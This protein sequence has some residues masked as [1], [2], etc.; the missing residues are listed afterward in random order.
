MLPHGAG[1]LVSE[2]APSSRALET[3]QLEAREQ[4]E[5]EDEQ[6]GH[7]SDGASS[8]GS[9]EEQEQAGRGQRHRRGLLAS[10][11]I[12]AEKDAS[13]P[14]KRKR[15]PSRR[16]V[17]AAESA[18]LLEQVIA[19]ENRIAARSQ[20]H[21]G[22]FP[23]GPGAH[24]ISWARPDHPQRPASAD[25]SEW[26]TGNVSTRAAASKGRLG[27]VMGPYTSFA[28]E[29]DRCS[30]HLFRGD[31][32]SKGTSVRWGMEGCGSCLSQPSSS[33]R[34]ARDAVQRIPLCRRPL[35]GAVEPQDLLGFGV[36]LGDVLHSRKEQLQK[37][38]QQRQE[39]P[40]SPESVQQQEEPQPHQQQQA[41]RGDPAFVIDVAVVG[42]GVAG[43]AAA[44]YLRR[45]GATV[46]VFEGR[47][48][49]G[50]RTFSSVMPER[51]LPDGR[52]VGQVVIDLG[53]SY[54][55]CVAAKPKADEKNAGDCRWRR[56]P[57]RSVSGIAAVLQPLVADVAGKQN[58]ESTLFA[59]W[60]DEASGRELP[61]FSV[62]KVHEL[63]DRLRERTAAKLLH[64]PPPLTALGGPGPPSAALPNTIPAAEFLSPPLDRVLRAALKRQRAL[65]ARGGG[66]RGTGTFTIGGSGKVLTAPPSFA[67]SKGIGE[68]YSDIP[69]VVAAASSDIQRVPSVC[70][71][72]C[73]G[74][75]EASGNLSLALLQH[76][77]S[78]PCCSCSSTDAREKYGHL[79]RRGISACRFDNYYPLGNKFVRKAIKAFGGCPICCT[80]GCGGASRFTEGKQIFAAGVDHQGDAGTYARP[81][82]LWGAPAPLFASQE[83]GK[84]A[85]EA[86]CES[87][88]ADGSA[89]QSSLTHPKG[90]D[91]GDL[92]TWIDRS[93]REDVLASGDALDGNNGSNGEGLAKLRPSPRKECKRQQTRRCSRTGGTTC[94]RSSNGTGEFVLRSNRFKKS[95]TSGAQAETRLVPQLSLHD[96]E[97]IRRS[98]WDAL[99]TSLCELLAEAEADGGESAVDSSCKE[100]T[101]DCWPHRPRGQFLLSPAEARMLLVVLQS[102]LGYV[103]DL[104]ELPVSAVKNY[105]YEVAAVGRALRRKLLTP[106][107]GAPPV[108]L[109]VPFP[110]SPQRLRMQQAAMEPVLQQEQRPHVHP[111]CASAASSA[112]KLVVEGWGWLPLFLCLQVIPFLVTDAI[113]Q[114]IHIKQTGSR[115]P[116]SVSGVPVA[117][118]DDA[119]DDG[120]LACTDDEGE[121]AKALAKS[122]PVLLRV[123]VNRRL[124][125]RASHGLPQAA[126]QQERPAHVWVHA[127]YCV[128]AVPLA[129]LALTPLP[130]PNQSFDSAGVATSKSRVPPTLGLIDFSPPLGADRRRALAR[131]KM[132]CHNKVVIRWHPDDVFWGTKGLQLNC[133]DQKFQFL[134]LHAYGKPGCLLAHCFPPFSS[135][136]G[137]LQ[138]D[139]EDPRVLFCGEHLSKAYFQCVDG[140][141]DTGLRAGEAVAH[142]CLQ[143]PLPPREDSRRFGL[144]FFCLPPGSGDHECGSF[145]SLVPNRHKQL[146]KAKSEKAISAEREDQGA[147][148][149]TTHGSSLPGCLPQCPFSGFPL[150]PLPRVLRGHYLTDQSDL[151]LTD[152]EGSNWADAGAGRRGPQDCESE[153]RAQQVAA[154]EEYF[155]AC[156]LSY[157]KKCSERVFQCVEVQ[158]PHQRCEGSNLLENVLPNNAC[159]SGEKYHCSPLPATCSAGVGEVE[160]ACGDGLPPLPE[161]SESAA[162]FQ[163]RLPTA[164]QRLFYRAFL[165]TY[166][167]RHQSASLTSSEQQGDSGTPPTPTH[168][169]QTTSSQVQIECEEQPQ[170][171]LL[172]DLLDAI[173]MCANSIKSE[174]SSAHPSEASLVLQQTLTRRLRR[175]SG[176]R[177]LDTEGFLVLLARNNKIIRDSV[178]R[179]IRFF[180]ESFSQRRGEKREV[181]GRK[182]QELSSTACE[183]ASLERFVK[184]LML[185]A[186][187]AHARN[188]KPPRMA[189]VAAGVLLMETLEKLCAAVPPLAV[190]ET[191]QE[192]AAALDALV[193]RSLADSQFVS[194]TSSDGV[195]Q[196]FGAKQG[197]DPDAHEPLQHEQL[198]WLCR[199][200]GDLLLC[201]GL[202]PASRIDNTTVENTSTDNGKNDCAPAPRPCCHVFHMGC[203]FPPPTPA[204]LQ[205]NARWSC[206]LCK[207]S[208]FRE[209][210]GL[211]LRQ[212]EVRQ[213]K[214]TQNRYQQPTRRPAHQTECERQHLPQQEESQQ[215]ED[216]DESGRLVSGAAEADEVEGYFL[217]HV[218]TSLRRLS[219]QKPGERTAQQLHLQL[220]ACEELQ[221]AALK[222]LFVDKARGVLACTRQVCKRL[223]FLSAKRRR[224]LAAA[225]RRRWRLRARADPSDIQNEAA[226]VLGASDSKKHSSSFQQQQHLKSAG[227]SLSSALEE[228]AGADS[229]SATLS[230]PAASC[231]S[232][233]RSTPA[234]WRSGGANHEERGGHSEAR[235]EQ[236]TRRTRRP[237][238]VR[239]SAQVGAVAGASRSPDRHLADV[240]AAAPAAGCTSAREDQAKGSDAEISET[241]PDEEFSEAESDG[242]FD[243]FAAAAQTVKFATALRLLAL[244]R[245]ADGTGLPLKLSALQHLQHL[246]EGC[247]CSLQRA[248]AAIDAQQDAATFGVLNEGGCTSARR[249]RKNEFCSCPA[250]GGAG[251][252]GCLCMRSARRAAIDALRKLLEFHRKSQTPEP[253]VRPSFRCLVPRICSSS[254]EIDALSQGDPFWRNRLVRPFRKRR[255]LQPRTTFRDA[256]DSDS[257]QA[258]RQQVALFAAQLRQL[259]QQ[260]RQLHPSQHS[261]NLM[262]ELRLSDDARARP[263]IPNAGLLPSSLIQPQSPVH[264]QRWPLGAGSVLQ[265][266]L[267]THS[268]SLRSLWQ[269]LQDAQR[270]QQQRL[271]GAGILDAL[272]MQ[273][274][275]LMQAQQQL[276]QQRCTEALHAAQK[277]RLEAAS[278]AG[279]PRGNLY[280]VDPE[281]TCRTQEIAPHMSVQSISAHGQ[282]AYQMQPWGTQTQALHDQQQRQQRLAPALGR[283]GS[284]TG[285]QQQHKDE[286]FCLLQEAQQDTAVQQQLKQRVYRLQQ[287]QKHLLQLQRHQR[288]AS[289]PHEGPPQL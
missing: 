232:R 271:P 193:L 94:N 70:P 54:M 267:N 78:D 49:V 76:D 159:D 141:F 117:G 35:Y 269:L 151:G 272:Q 140:A 236:L 182:P 81:L 53:A 186:L 39:V 106:Q 214:Q 91:I 73:S 98:A 21:A 149:P 270:R 238:L 260:Q 110:S 126:E 243:Q 116:G 233:R 101:K 15:T 285:Q 72:A 201:D 174:G 218:L 34:S 254:A 108:P 3:M 156:C 284:D 158:H 92:H 161:L 264:A 138:T 79:V 198:C 219:Q 42:A 220:A 163:S 192:R 178:L 99:E 80:G 118:K 204:E 239:T 67:E 286:L 250:Q 266:Q 217:R 112:D 249:G 64:L 68:E 44:A 29:Y 36:P 18:L 177:V 253:C 63:L 185:P 162:S 209:Q 1:R 259:Q 265:A 210:R 132:G 71:R 183:P 6:P 20:S 231:A 17:E 96:N 246:T 160:W 31:A 262:Q 170:P 135:G 100:G 45:C 154:S 107:L 28:Y 144:D 143:L 273:H 82:L 263:V 227:T 83:G 38:T 123:E 33:Q 234:S 147:A 122:H 216:E 184:E 257:T 120:S 131:Y 46:M 11:P 61:F 13:P 88:A 287:L 202:V 199:G 247:L 274:L 175:G 251:A 288:Q 279:T 145:V 9:Y 280:S 164:A 102:R 153:R 240:E 103:G 155:L 207:A 125:Y 74:V 172:T 235:K 196:G 139:Q 256:R 173:F 40:P 258:R 105:P 225:K 244:V 129:Q 84:E 16:V 124:Q 137:G 252:V 22:T 89:L 148:S 59:S 278:A 77:T 203:A 7:Q 152:A 187:P 242:C 245:E 208:T 62:L 51:E 113:V 19:Q 47:H 166:P 127:K 12:V 134:N 241:S 26:F 237:V 58:W 8:S 37:Q 57:S 277:A 23:T 111:F 87:V 32:I 229:R 75:D 248:P 200:E 142:E 128:V 95:S 181:L 52:K 228:K 4:E 224:L 41:V 176:S 281:I 171:P 69:A 261:Q 55:H 27:Q 213:N 14:M 85:E 5:Q 221:L 211:Q 146:L 43:L 2:E 48:R 93:R 195:S 109:V 104:R 133:L 190:R 165:S 289:T 230:S 169:L 66:S 115:K 60:F 268:D 136:Y 191:I 223:D 275:R 222:R 65:I 168:E 189:A 255:P 150:P 119:I 206:P 86:Q 197:E 194:A 90:C 130:S 212:Q 179:P 276:L 180:A 121:E 188:A 56:E 157:I 97:G 25:D 167:L 10:S 114:S 283:A 50:G 282:A 226:H 24:D 215:Q 205:P 30:L